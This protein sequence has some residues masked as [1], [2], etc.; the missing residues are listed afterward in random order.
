[1]GSTGRPKPL[2]H[3]S[4]VIDDECSG[5]GRLATPIARESAFA[6]F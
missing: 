5:A 3:D 6:S 1:L 2:G 4:G